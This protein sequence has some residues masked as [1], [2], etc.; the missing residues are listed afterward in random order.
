MA[1][2]TRMLHGTMRPAKVALQ[3]AACSKL[4][5]VAAITRV[6]TGISYLVR[7]RVES[8]VPRPHRERCRGLVPS[9]PAPVAESHDCIKGMNLTQL[10]SLDIDICQGL[11]QEIVIP[12]GVNILSGAL[13]TG[14]ESRVQLYGS[15]GVS[16]RSKGWTT[17]GS[18]P[19]L[20]APRSN[21][22]LLPQFCYR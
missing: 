15:S 3:L 8:S 6:S 4:T 16:S 11:R 5:C 22:R 12:T 2:A 20:S 10:P 21:W 1:R 9:A 18:L 17:L 14:E 13:K 7:R 19:D